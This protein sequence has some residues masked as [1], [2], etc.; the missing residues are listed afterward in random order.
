MALVELNR[1]ER[2]IGILSTL[3][4]LET[5]GIDALDAIVKLVDVS[6]AIRLDLVEL[7][8]GLLGAA[9]DL[10]LEHHRAIEVHL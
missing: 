8:P 4:A 6:L 7:E 10:D 1:L 5:Y 3:H 2:T 9:H